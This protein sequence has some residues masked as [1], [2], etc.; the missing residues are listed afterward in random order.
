MRNNSPRWREVLG[1]P[2]Q[3][4]G[5]ARRS[6]LLIA[7]AVFAALGALL[8]RPAF[9]E[10]TGPRWFTLSP[11]IWFA[12][13][14]TPDTPNF[15]REIYFV[16]SFGAALTI[17]PPMLEGFSVLLVG[18]YGVGGG[19]A[20]FNPSII[21][22]GMVLDADVERLDIEGL[23]I[24]QLPNLPLNVFI[25]SRY[26]RLE[27][28]LKGKDATTSVSLNVDNEITIVKA[29]LGASGAL[30]ED[31][32]HRLFGNISA[33]VGFAKTNIRFRVAPSLQVRNEIDDTNPTV[34]VNVGYDYSFRNSLALQLRYRTSLVFFDDAIGQKATDITHGP[35][36]SLSVSW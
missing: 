19:N 7:L 11:R 12:L 1:V 30:T 32:S 35:E 27:E 13:T 6:L 31:G 16:P 29:G 18:L 5:H 9:A 15:F 26:V 34:D 21:S 2:V 24:Y 20:R 22:S 3:R 17:T 4:R 14:D 8:P 28:K 33:G 10:D 36:L 23:L 25:G